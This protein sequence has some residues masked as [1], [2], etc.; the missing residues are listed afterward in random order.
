MSQ[1]TL[2]SI[3]PFGIRDKVGYAFGDIANDFTFILSSSFLLKFYTDVMGVNAIFVGLMMMAARV[4]DAFTDITMGRIVDTAKIGKNGKFRPWILRGAGPV[5][6][7]SFLLYPTWF[8]N[9]GMTF[10]I[11]WMFATYLLWGSVFYTMVNVPYGSMASG[12][13]DDPKQRTQLSTFR[14]VGATIAS[15][16]IGTGVPMFAYYTDAAGNRVFNGSVF[17]I[18]ALVCSV[19]AV[20]CYLVCYFSC[21][22]RVR[23]EP[24]SKIAGKKNNFVKNI[25]TNRA[26]LSLICANICLML[27]QLTI[28]AMANYVFPN[29]YGD[30]NAQVFA[31]LVGSFGIFFV[32][33]LAT[34]LATKFGKK[35]TGAVSCAIAS[36]GYLVCL[37]AR[38]ATA[39]G[40]LL[41]TTLAG[42]GM[43]LFAMLCWAYIVD[44]IDYAEIRNGVREDGT[45]YS[46]YTFARK[47]SQAAS[48][49]LS[50]ALLTLAGYTTATAFDPAVTGH[51]FE[52]SCAV[53]A[54]GFGLTALILCVWYPLN[55]KS[56]EENCAVLA[57]KREAAQQ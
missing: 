27:S 20:L 13:T 9:M 33:P 35:E 18:I 39:W 14:T 25:F 43:G 34:L 8:Q 2:T 49:G 48:S 46:C 21:T 51:I 54:V 1:N 40:Y 41:C 26:L 56:V 5:A 3:R 15:M 45:I 53:P 32:A 28:N 38:P 50:G 19:L 22:E 7:M 52:I 10:K 57:A 24:Q 31:S 11:V 16:V 36:I 37:I 29:Y 47:L 55:K 4:V 6:L 44:V 17:S 30:T 23:I 12:L 42:L